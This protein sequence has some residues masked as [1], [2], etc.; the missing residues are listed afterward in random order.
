MVADYDSA[1][2]S[3][4]YVWGTKARAMEH[5]ADNAGALRALL[6]GVAEGRVSE[7]EALLAVAE[8]PGLG[9]VKAGFLLQLCAGV[10][11]CVD[12]H[13]LRRLGLTR[14]AVALPKSLSPRTKARKAFAYSGIV[15][16]AGGTEKLWDDWCRYL[17]VQ[18]PGR[19]PGGAEQVSRLHWQALGLEE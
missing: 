3:S 8:T 11:G 12:V 4:R 9:L 15:A 19:F 14:S 18:Q 10:S 16:A 5:I 7:G 6:A 13:N 2:V 1:G 17:A